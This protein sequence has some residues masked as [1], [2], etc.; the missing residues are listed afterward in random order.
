MTLKCDRDHSLIILGKCDKCGAWIHWGRDDP[1]AEK[2]MREFN[3]VV[4]K[5]VKS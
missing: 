3:K 1:S 5:A 2:R 4:Q